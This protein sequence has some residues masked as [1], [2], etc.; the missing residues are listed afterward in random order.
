MKYYIELRFVCAC[1]S[2][3]HAILHRKIFSRFLFKENS[4]LE[5]TKSGAGLKQQLIIK[6]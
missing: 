5:L 3:K 6:I 4:I 1:K 2:I